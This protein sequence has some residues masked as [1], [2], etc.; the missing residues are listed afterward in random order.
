MADDTSKSTGSFGA[1]LRT[2]R[3][4]KNLSMHD[5]YKKAT[6]RTYYSALEHGRKV[7]T[8][9]KIDEIANALGVHPLALLLL[10]YAQDTDQSMLRLIAQAK[11]DLDELGLWTEG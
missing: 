5:V 6:G 11:V 10:S 3:L 9:A 7:P 8:L 4:G 2:I 1:A